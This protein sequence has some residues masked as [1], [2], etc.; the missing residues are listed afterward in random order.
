MPI[1]QRVK[2]MPFLVWNVTLHALLFTRSARIYKAFTA[3]M[4]LSE[5][6]TDNR[7]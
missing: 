7:L 5:S 3:G 1:L 4:T 2:I 6:L